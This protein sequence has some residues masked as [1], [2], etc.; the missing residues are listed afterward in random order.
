MHERPLQKYKPL[1][2][3]LLFATPPFH[4]IKT[5]DMRGSLKSCLSLLLPRPPF[6]V[7]NLSRDLQP[8]FFIH[9]MLTFILFSL[10]FSKII[11]F[12]FPAP[13]VCLDSRV[14]GGCV[15][16]GMSTMLVY[17]PTAVLPAVS[18][19][20]FHCDWLAKEKRDTCRLARGLSAVFVIN[21]DL[22]LS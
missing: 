21:T 18:L 16:S 22:G 17:L 13:F 3:L 8:L 4:F 15:R 20:L 10:L 6:Y 19:L 5:K 2:F 7:F 12:Y 11:H 14:I 1:S 9:F